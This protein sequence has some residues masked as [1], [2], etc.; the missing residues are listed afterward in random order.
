MKLWMLHVAT[1]LAHVPTV[2]LFVSVQRHD[3]NITLARYCWDNKSV[4]ML[5]QIF[6]RENTRYSLTLSLC[7]FVKKVDIIN[8]VNEHKTPVCHIAHHTSSETFYFSPQG[9]HRG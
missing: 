2:L 5:N 8:E 3:E 9:I 4:L 6:N 1:A 7:C